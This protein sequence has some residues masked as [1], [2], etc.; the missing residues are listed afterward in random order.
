[1]PTLSLLSGTRGCHNCP[2]YHYWRQSCH[3]DHSRFPVCNGGN[4]CFLLTH[5]VLISAVTE[6]FRSP[7]H[8]WSR[9]LHFHDQLFIA[10]LSHLLYSDNSN[11]TVT[12]KT[13]YWCT[14]SLGNWDEFASLVIYF[15]K[16]NQ[17]MLMWKF[18]AFEWRDWIWEQKF[19]MDLAKSFCERCKGLNLLG[20][21]RWCIQCKMSPLLTPFEQHITP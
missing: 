18:L 20:D 10:K 8:T 2:R 9:M 12:R 7:L 1:M 13:V 4:V 11:T 6:C 5:H 14:K 21:R 16:I 19:A 3:H 15:Q 17:Q